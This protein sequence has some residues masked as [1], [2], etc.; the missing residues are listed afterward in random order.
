MVI[1]AAPLA[2]TEVVVSTDYGVIRVPQGSGRRAGKCGSQSVA[3][4]PASAGGYR[5]TE[6]A[7]TACG[8]GFK[9]WQD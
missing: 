9:T 4:V 1:H 5:V 6:A 3:R 2:A 8:V 7:L